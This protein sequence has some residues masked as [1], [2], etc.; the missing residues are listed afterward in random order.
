MK[1]LFLLFICCYS[2][3]GFSQLQD[4]FSAIR[5]MSYFEGY[6]FLHNE[7]SKF[8]GTAE[9]A[10]YWQAKGTLYS[11]LGKYDQAIS[12]FDNQFDKD[13]LYQQDLILS[14]KMSNQD[15]LV[16]LYSDYDVVL[17]NEAHHKSQHRAFMY[18]QLNFLKDAG[19]KYLAIEALNTGIYL[20]STLVKR[21]YPII[22]KTG[23]YISDPIFGLLIRHAIELGFTLIEYESYNKNREQEQADNIFAAY[24]PKKGKLVVYAGFGHICEADNKLLMASY[25]KEKL[26][27]DLLTIT[28]TLPRQF[29]PI[30]S[31]ADSCEFYLLPRSNECYDYTIIPNFKESDSNIPYWFDWMH[32]R[33]KSLSD[34]YNEKI[35][36][37]VLVQLFKEDEREKAVPVYQHMIEKESEMNIQLPFVYDGKYRL[38]IQNKESKIVK[39]IDLH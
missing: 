14:D 20:D 6:M 26:G 34:F 30:T 38:V 31:Q 39:L 7:E 29:K 9:E 12:L 32:C 22:Q 24:K 21:G 4:P 16:Q 23:I 5:S 19:Y 13:T 18:S 8:I 11:F 25:L 28:Q 15:E 17:F 37:P 3:S 35:K 36:Y 10:Y 27:K 1:K 33:Y 2:F